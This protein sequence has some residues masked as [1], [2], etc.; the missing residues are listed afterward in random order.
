ME[1]WEALFVTSI[2]SLK[3]E[4]GSSAY[5]GTSSFP[6]SSF[7]I[8]SLDCEEVLMMEQNINIIFKIRKCCSF[9]MLLSADSMVPSIRFMHLIQAPNP[10]YYLAYSFIQHISWVAY[11][12]RQAHYQ[13]R[14]GR[15][16]KHRLFS[17]GVY[18]ITESRDFY[19]TKNQTKQRQG[20]WCRGLEHGLWS[21]MDPSSNPA[22]AAY[23][24]G[25]GQT[26]QHHCA[27]RQHQ[28]Y[29]S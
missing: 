10:F 27:Q 14:G 13:A 4:E 20:V 3:Y 22:Q 1:W 12:I 15:A 18:C 17:W 28:Y 6:F 24:D 26:T 8:F 29:T 11:T 9:F 19:E 16:M 25:S 23:C 21:Q 2:S 5:D 7:F